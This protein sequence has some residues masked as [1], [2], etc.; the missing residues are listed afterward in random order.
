MKYHWDIKYLYGG[1]TAFIVLAL[2]I[3]FYNSISKMTAIFSSIGRLL[4]ILMPVIYGA[5]IAY[6]MTP[7]VNF[8]EKKVFF[9]L[10]KK[11]KLNDYKKTK[12]IIRSFSVFISLALLLLMIYG[13]LNMLI[14]QLID[15]IT[16]F[17]AKAPEYTTNFHSW[18]MKFV[19]DNPTLEK[20][21]TVVGDYLIKIINDLL[22]Q[23]KIFLTNLSSGIL[24]VVVVLKN[25]V[26]G[27]IISIYLLNSK[28][29][30]TGQSKKVLYALFKPR[31]ANKILNGARFVHK[32]FSGFIVGKI[33]DS[34]IIGII[35]YIVTAIMHTPYNVLISVIIGVT[36]VIPFFGPYI[37]AIPT[38]LLILLVNP[39]QAVYFVIFIII[40]QTFDG[41]IL[42]PRILSESTDLTSFWIIFAILLMGGLFGIVGM[43]VGV[44]IFAVIY[45]AISS[46]IERLLYLRRMPVDSSEYLKLDHIELERGAQKYGEF[47]YREEPEDDDLN[48]TVRVKKKFFNVKFHLKDY[49]KAMVST[50][51]NDETG[52][53][54]END[55]E[56]K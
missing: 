49:F 38:T 26:I 28:E 33:I 40:L 5:V 46:Y 24:D 36:N 34:V 9:P 19:S 54:K 21:F 42:G 15:S 48:D 4:D 51:N 14:P 22:P 20:Y 27:F 8:L 2:A 37:G 23:L 55:K 45:A 3:L 6:L 44:P 43:F 41:N 56:D 17:A 53:D 39:I 35:C 18:L 25:V 11:L 12:K 32:K 13:L 47:I 30:F 52:S 10:S 7:I 1:I 50:S 29:E 16:T 31:K